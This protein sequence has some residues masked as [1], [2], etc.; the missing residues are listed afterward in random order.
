MDLSIIVPVYN[1]EEY[2][3]EC[4]K[5]I[6][7][8][9]E[10]KYEVILVNDG[11]KD[12]SLEIMQEFKSLYGDKTIIVDKQNGGLSSARNAGLK[13]AQGEYVAFIDSDDFIDPNEFEKIVRKSKELDLDIGVGNMRY[14]VPGRI[15]EPLFRSP[16]VKELDVTTGTEFLWNTMQS[17]KCF[18]E[19]VVDDIYK[20]EFLMK[21]NL[22]F[23]E[24][25]IHEDTEF[26]N[27]AYLRAERVKFLN[28]TFYFYRQREGSIMNKVS[29]KSVISLENI[30]DT[31][32]EEYKKSS[33]KHCKEA[34]ATLIISFYSTIIYKRYNG[35]GEYK[36]VYERYKELYNV[37]KKDNQGGL[38]SKLLSHSVF[39]P[40]LLRKMM[41]KEIT[42]IQKVPKF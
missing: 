17:P 34:L 16:R 13:L 22:F 14:Y 40:N 36:K 4:L 39:I 31:L 32:F 15:G 35:V 38:E 41:D 20:R 12:R 8:I 7:K 3:E 30:C 25:I 5:S 9:D 18:R 19:E 42:N 1:V 21:N 2:L 6:Y 23:N 10:I 37:L 27:L 24:S 33:D 26:T 28:T 11:S 29:E